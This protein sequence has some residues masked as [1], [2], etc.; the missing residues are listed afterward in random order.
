MRWQLTMRRR[1][2]YLNLAVRELIARHKQRIEE[3]SGRG[4]NKLIALEG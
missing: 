1:S 4:G 2:F 3:L